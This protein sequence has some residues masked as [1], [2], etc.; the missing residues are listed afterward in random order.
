[1]PIEQTIKEMIADVAK[2][3]LKELNFS[4]NSDFIEEIGLDSFQIVNFVDKLDKAFNISFGSKS[5]DFDSL[6]SWSTLL[7]NIRSQMNIISLFSQSVKKYP[8]KA[9]LQCFSEKL[10]YQQ[11]DDYSNQIAMKITQKKIPLHSPILL[12]VDKSLASVVYILGILKAGCYYIPVAS[13]IPIHRLNYLLQNSKAHTAFLRNYYDQF[14]HREDLDCFLVE[15]DLIQLIN[16][17]GKE[18]IEFHSSPIQS[19]DPAC[20]LY[21]SG[22]T[23]HPK[24]VLISHAGMAAFFRGVEFCMNTSHDSIYLNTAPF[25]FD[26]SIIDTLFPLTKGATVHLSPQV[27]LPNYIL[28]LIDR[29]KI[30]HMC[31]VSSTM[32]LL[33]GNDEQIAGYDISSLTTIMTGA[34]LL[35]QKTLS[36]ILK[37]SPFATILNGYGLTE[38]TCACTVFTINKENVKDYLL[39]PIGQPLAGVEVKILSPEGYE[40]NRGELLIHGDQIML[41]YL[42]NPEATQAAFIEYEGKRYYKTGDIV[43]YDE[44]QNLVFHG[45]NDVQVKIHGY[46]VDLNEI[47]YSLLSMKEVNEVEVFVKE[48]T[49]TAVL[50]LSSEL[51]ITDEKAVI[52][53]L[54]TKLSDI[55][56]KYMHPKKW[57]ILGDLPKL[58]TGKTDLKKLKEVYNEFE[59]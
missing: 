10:T 52:N 23:G 16:T 37:H 58:P 26:V 13:N 43:S 11:L 24:G 20:C 17:N 53:V 14:R 8:N 38:T 32:N 51:E 15:Q 57:V 5:T 48:S 18:L 4:P 19:T 9:A 49:I 42:N 22:S 45:R 1:M 21:T 55:L 31:G 3:D 40:T 6:K 2:I 12:E 39:Y 50:S 30:T 28:P 59:F 25:I 56:P 29:E 34:E 44:N 35:H 33:F 47:K 36:T 54:E 41:E 27:I 7:A 46:R